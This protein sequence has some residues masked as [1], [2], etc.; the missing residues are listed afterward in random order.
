MAKT[1]KI[2]AKYLRIALAEIDPL[3]A[4]S[5]EK[6]LAEIKLKA[7]APTKIPITFD[8]KTGSWVGITEEHLSRWKAAYPALDVPLKLK[9]LANWLLANPSR[10]KTNYE[11]FIVNCLTRDQD[12]ARSSAGNPSAKRTADEAAED[13]ARRQTE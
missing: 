10:L 4:E 8:V 3:L 6:E 5:M 2:L 13:W 9:Q 11:R 1:E 12:R 7:A